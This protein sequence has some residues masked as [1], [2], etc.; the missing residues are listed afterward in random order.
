MTTTD[1]FQYGLGCIALAIMLAGYGAWRMAFA[2]AVYHEGLMIDPLL[3][4]RT[5]VER[6]HMKHRCADCSF[7][8]ELRSIVRG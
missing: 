2:V 8:A 6:R 7:T 4:P 3:A 5:W 1:F